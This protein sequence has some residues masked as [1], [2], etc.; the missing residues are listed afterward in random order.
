MKNLKSLYIKN[1]G[2]GEEA[3]SPGGRRKDDEEAPSFAG[4]PWEDPIPTEIC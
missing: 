2:R 3:P 4:F 1:W